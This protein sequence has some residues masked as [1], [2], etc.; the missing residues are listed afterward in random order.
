[1]AA[2]ASALPSPAMAAALGAW[3]QHLSA[4][5]DAAPAT[6]RAYAT[7]LR[8][9]LQFLGAHLGGAPGVPGVLAAGGPEMRAFLAHERNRG[10]G[11]RT[12]AR[13]LAA[14]RGFTAWLA[15]REG[16]DAS[17]FLAAAR[18]PRFRRS[19]PR[20]LS[21]PDARAVLAAAGAQPCQD[22]IAARD[23]ALVTL[24]YACGLR[25]AEALGLRGADHPLPETLTIRGKGGKDRLVPVLPVAR[26]AVARYAELCPHAITADGALFRGLRGKAL[27]SRGLR[28][29]MA[30][31]RATL[32]LPASATPHALRHS[33]AT[34]L[35]QSG[36]DLRT[37][38]ELLGHASLATT[39]TYTA[40]DQ[41]HLMK[42]YAHAHPRA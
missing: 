17:P 27:D 31:L 7:D 9:W 4:L 19:L 11:A 16:T 8:L 3:L 25:S 6:L 10:V 12:L 41:T 2:P 40:V 24:L 42:V 1:M 22:W 28:A 39:Q 34:H 26:A 18:A 37:I 38:Q 35:L 14:I 20:P 30:T 15:D 36:A 21:L 23:A 5:D 33:F 13:R 32:G 29:L